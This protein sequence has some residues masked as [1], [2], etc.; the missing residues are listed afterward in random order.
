[1]RIPAGWPE[2]EADASDLL[3]QADRRLAR[4]GATKAMRV[5]RERVGRG[6]AGVRG[7]LERDV[8][9]TPEMAASVRS[10]LDELREHL[11]RDLTRLDRDA[12]RARLAARRI[13][14]GDRIRFTGRTTLDTGTVLR[15][16]GRRISVAPTEGG[17]P[18]RVWE[19]EAEVLP[20]PRADEDEIARLRRRYTAPRGGQSGRPGAMTND[21]AAAEIA[22]RIADAPTR[23]SGPAAS[24]DA[25]L[26][27]AAA[28]FDRAA[29]D[30]IRDRVARALASVREL[31]E[32]QEVTEAEARRTAAAIDAARGIAADEVE[33]TRA[34]RHV[35]ASRKRDAAKHIAA[36]V[37]ELEWYA[38]ELAGRGSGPSR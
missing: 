38:T 3:T 2:L 15:V 22:R 23:G 37:R 13:R 18:W 26:D 33:L 4:P 24:V 9:V 12:Q 32:R 36:A 35:M 27:E 31:E 16:D 6:V 11:R 20:L 1:M 28:E 34:R 5:A 14:A 8:D 17:G 29:A 21:E 7:M 30:V 25:W 10:A 19:E